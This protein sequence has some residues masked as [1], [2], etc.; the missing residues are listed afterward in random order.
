M[1]LRTCRCKDSLDFKGEAVVPTRSGLSCL[2]QTDIMLAQGLF[3]LDGAG[4]FQC[5]KRRLP[6]GENRLDRENTG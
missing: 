6:V 1:S 3:I 5:G 4:G 2:I